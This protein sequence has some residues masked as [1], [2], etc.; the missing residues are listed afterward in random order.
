MHKTLIALLAAP[1]LAL[2]PVA[3]TAPQAITATGPAGQLAGVLTPPTDDGPVILVIP[4]SGPTD[5][6]GNNPMGVTAASYRL[7]AEALGARG[8]GSVRIDK[9]GMFGSAATGVDPNAV[10]IAAYADDVAAWAD[11]ARTAT[12]RQCV[13]LLGHSEGGLIALA[14]VQRSGPVCGV[15]LVA[16]PGRKLGDVMRQQLRANP[17]NAPILDDALSAIDRLETGERVDVSAM[18]PALQGLFAPQIQ[19][20]LIDLFSHDPA[21]LARDVKLPLLIVQGGNDTQ[22]PEAD[23][24]ALRAAQPAARY[25]V[26]PAM[27]HVLK[28]VPQG[29]PAAN[30]AAY[31]D[32]SRPISPGL[33]DAVA[34]FVARGGR[35]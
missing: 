30:A 4:G 23:G 9:R 10:T 21:A 19:G 31:G 8:I 15:I 26:L 13:W 33:V 34:D 27:N 24:D 2:A 22:V 3:A 16:A 12:G 6:D 18:H 25:L 28:D 7:L 32:P 1:S 11:A 20:Y 14:A 35:G 17:A 5:R 29:D